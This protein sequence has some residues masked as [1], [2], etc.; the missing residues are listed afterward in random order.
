MNYTGSTIHL[1]PATRLARP[2]LAPP[3]PTGTSPPRRRRPHG[4]K[5]FSSCS[6]HAPPRRCPPLCGALW[7]RVAAIP[8]ATRPG[9]GPAASAALGAGGAGGT[10]RGAA[11]SRRWATGEPAGRALSGLGGVGTVALAPRAFCRGLPGSAA[12]P[13]CAR[14]G[15]AFPPPSGGLPEEFRNKEQFSFGPAKGKAA[16]GVRLPEGTGPRECAAP[17]PA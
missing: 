5:G 6:A 9:P 15:E 3:F 10:G 8:L 4:G 2:A 16:W 14:V 11:R 7:E 12:P 13:S 17:R 1:G